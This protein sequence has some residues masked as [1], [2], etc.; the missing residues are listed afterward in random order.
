MSTT[1]QN[2]KQEVISQLQSYL[3]YVRFNTVNFGNRLLEYFEV[4]DFSL[5]RDVSSIFV[6]FRGSEASRG[7]HYWVNKKDFEDFKAGKKKLGVALDFTKHTIENGHTV[8]ELN[9][10]KNKLDNKLNEVAKL[11]DLNVR[12]SNGLLYKVIDVQVKVKDETHVENI[13]K[14]I[15][16]ESKSTK[17]FI[18]SKV[19]LKNKVEKRGGLEIELGVTEEFLSKNDV[20]EALKIERSILAEDLKDW[21]MT[22]PSEEISS[23]L[24][25]KITER[26]SELSI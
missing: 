10:S 3:N 16:K 1:I 14:L 17:D 15:V 23:T 19:V 8:F 9:L 25:K 4:S 12:Y 6:E 20:L 24:R 21:I 22:L 5:T 11:K 13:V 7:N 18:D 2:N 26:I